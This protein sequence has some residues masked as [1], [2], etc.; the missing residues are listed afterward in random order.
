VAISNYSAAAEFAMDDRSEIQQTINLYHQAG[1]LGDLALMVSTFTPDGVWEF[2]QSGRRFE[3]HP[4]IHEAAVGFTAALEYV[5]QINAPALITV[6]G[7]TA[8]ATSSI[9]ETAKYAGR[10]EGIEAFGVYVDRLV[11]TADGWRFTHRAFDLKWMHRVPILP[12]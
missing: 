11:R 7:D 10:D 9:R 4:A 2:T 1:S 6:D 8:A 5:A 12:S 3:G